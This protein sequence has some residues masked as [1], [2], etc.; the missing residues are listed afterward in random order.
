MGHNARDSHRK[1]TVHYS[2]PDGKG[3]MVMVCKVTLMN[4]FN[5]TKKK[6]KPWGL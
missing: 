4:M 5:M 6:K 2:L 1:T 3:N